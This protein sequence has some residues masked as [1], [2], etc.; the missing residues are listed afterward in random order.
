MTIRTSTLQAI[1]ALALDAALVGCDGGGG[2][3]LVGGISG[4]VGS[5]PALESRLFDESTPPDVIIGLPREYGNPFRNHTL[6]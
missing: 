1:A 3:W 6:G 2:S 4:R 5:K